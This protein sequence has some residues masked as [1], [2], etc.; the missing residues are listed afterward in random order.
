MSEETVLEEETQREKK[1]ESET[2]TESSVLMSAESL[3]QC[4]L[5][6]M[7]ISFITRETEIFVHSIQAIV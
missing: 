5:D 3:Y 4:R 1:S 7:D 2:G 6:C